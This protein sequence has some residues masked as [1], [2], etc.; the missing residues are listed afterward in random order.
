MTNRTDGTWKGIK[1]AA[2]A[3]AI[4]GRLHVLVDELDPLKSHKDHVETKGE[5][6]ALLDQ[7]P[8]QDQ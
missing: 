3:N 7:F 5:I 4:R 8:E 1:K 6:A 2:L